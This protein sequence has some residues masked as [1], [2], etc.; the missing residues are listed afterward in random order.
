MREHP[1]PI[2]HLSARDRVHGRTH[3]QLRRSAGTDAESCVVHAHTHA[4]EG[5]APT[6][7]GSP[8]A[9]GHNR[10]ERVRGRYHY[11]R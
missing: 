5:I 6:P 11:L 3:P 4:T 7:P 10:C 1:E 2:D 9:A 8:S